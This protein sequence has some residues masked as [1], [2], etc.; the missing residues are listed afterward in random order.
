MDVQC[1]WIT[2]R[3]V[4][5]AICSASYH[6]FFHDHHFC[7]CSFKQSECVF[8]TKQTFM[9]RLHRS[10]RLMARFQGPAQQPWKQTQWCDTGSIYPTAAAAPALRWQARLAPPLIPHRRWCP[11]T[12]P[13]PGSA[14][15]TPPGDHSDSSVAG[16]A[17]LP[18]MW[19]SWWCYT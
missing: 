14:P 11:L 9:Y 13:P 2:S 16:G 17:N 10:G 8:T 3:D 12:V 5:M 15:Y 4:G 1:D 18:A 6:L 19:W 7:E